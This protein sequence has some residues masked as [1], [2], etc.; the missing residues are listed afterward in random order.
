MGRDHRGLCERQR[1]LAGG[2]DE[3]GHGKEKG[4]RQV[5]APGS[6]WQRWVTCSVAGLDALEVLLGHPRHHAAQ[7]S[8][9]LFDLV[10]F[11]GLEQG[12]VFLEAATFAALAAAAA[13]TR[14]LSSKAAK[15]TSWLAVTVFVFML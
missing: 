10:F 15:A 12:V 3:F 11:P 6:F 9:G 8:T 14:V 5:S 2:E 7:I 13:V 4:R 1:A